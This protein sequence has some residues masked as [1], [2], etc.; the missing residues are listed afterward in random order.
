[1][2][3]D[4][5]VL[6]FSV[7]CCAKNQKN[8]LANLVCTRCLVGYF[9]ISLIHVSPTYFPQKKFF[10]PKARSSLSLPLLQLEMAEF[11]LDRFNG[12]LLCG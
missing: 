12:N 2:V 10:P 4:M 3:L 9:T 8:F 11:W 1:M 5:V 7:R 6:Y